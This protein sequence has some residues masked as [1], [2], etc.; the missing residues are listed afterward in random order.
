MYRAAVALDFA[1][2]K[3]GGKAKFPG[4]TNLP[5]SAP[6]GDADARRRDR[7]RVVDAWDK[8]VQGG[9]GSERLDSMLAAQGISPLNTGSLIGAI[10][11]AAAILHGSGINGVFTSTA[12]DP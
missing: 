2:D 9:S 12:A 4:D 6:L 10:S 7:R 1:Q 11:K 8:G 5:Y 3:Y